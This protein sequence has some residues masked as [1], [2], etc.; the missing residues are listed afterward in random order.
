LEGKSNVHKHIE[1]S[2]QT[3]FYAKSQHHRSYA[4]TK[5]RRVLGLTPNRRKQSI[6]TILFSFTHSSQG[7]LAVILG[8][9]FIYSRNTA[10]LSLKLFV[11]GR[12]P[13]SEPVYP[14]LHRQKLIP[15]IHRIRKTKIIPVNTSVTSRPHPTVT[16]TA[17]G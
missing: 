12:I 13:K 14:L 11:I 17:S 9:S 6:W 7:S 3:T 2:N 1:D 16:Q 5:S 4:P 15:Y 10:I 8:I